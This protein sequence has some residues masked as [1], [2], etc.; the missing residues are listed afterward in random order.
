LR[1]DASDLRVDDTM[2]NA[3]SK[4]SLLPPKEEDDVLLK[5]LKDLQEKHR[6]ELKRLKIEQN[7]NMNKITENLEETSQS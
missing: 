6:I 5:Y 2:T 1:K 7:H 3:A 4:L